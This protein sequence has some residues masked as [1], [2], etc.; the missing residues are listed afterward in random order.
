MPTPIGI[1]LGTTYSVIGCYRNDRVEIISDSFG[2][3]LIPSMAYY[4]P[5]TGE[6]SVGHLAY[7][8]SRICPPNL[9]KGQCFQ[10]RNIGF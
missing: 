6:V 9:L 7:D 5:T 8:K 10:T 4:D 1:D 3:R 2:K